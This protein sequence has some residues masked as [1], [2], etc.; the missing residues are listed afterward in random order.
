[1]ANK[2]GLFFLCPC[3]RPTASA[4]PPL[5][6]AIIAPMYNGSL[7]VSFD[8]GTVVLRG[9]DPGALADMPHVRRDPR[10]DSL[11]AEARPYRSLIENLRRRQIPYKDEARTSDHTPWPLH[12]ERLPFPHQTEAVNAW[13]QAGARG[14]VVL[15]TGTGKTHVAVLAINKAE[16]PT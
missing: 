10:T 11:P 9:G 2:T 14:V 5:P 15:P 1:Q 12:R 16:R 6:L 4:F 8:A 7:H 3:D 13:W